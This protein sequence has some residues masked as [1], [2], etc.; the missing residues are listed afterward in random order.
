MESWLFRKAVTAVT[1]TV[2]YTLSMS[3][4][5]ALDQLELPGKTL[6]PEGIAADNVSGALYV[7]G[8]AH[9]EILK[10]FDGRWQTFKTA[11]SDGLKNTIGLSVDGERHRLWVCNTRFL[12]AGED[13]IDPAITPSILVFDT[14]TGALLKRFDIEADGLPHFFNDVTLGPDGAAYVSDSLAPVIWRMDMGDG[15]ASRFVQSK[16]FQ[17]QPEY[18]LNGIVLTPDGKHLI[19]TIP[20][21]EIGGLFRVTLADRRVQAISLDQA[22]SGGDG[23]VFTDSNQLIA[24]MGGVTGVQLDQHYLTGKVRHYP[25]LVDQFDFATTADVQ[26]NSLYVVNSQLDHFVPM[27]QNDSPPTLPFTLTRVPL[28][29]LK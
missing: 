11:H 26:G 8:L 20:G 16:E 3:H 28:N 12:V 18:N 15:Q 7:G 27:F 2:L 14:D 21:R 5:L 25:A 4:A 1:L 10:F 22:F 13:A 24:V 6:Y 29:T 17:L 19:V 23:L 9:G